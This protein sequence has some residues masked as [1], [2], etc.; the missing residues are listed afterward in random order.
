MVKIVLAEGADDTFLPK[1]HSTE[2][3]GVDLRAFIKEPV[4]LASGE[5]RLIPVG[6]HM[7]LQKG[8]EAQ[9]RPRS[10][11]AVKH[12]VSV[13]NTP[14][15]IDSDYRGQVMVVLINHGKESFTVNPGDRIAQMVIADVRM[16]RFEKVDSLDQLSKTDRGSGG[17]GSTGVQ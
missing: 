6:F 2:A 13:V 1:R 11:L 17:G 10:G 8:T 4:V 7:E 9:I 12:A 5:H 15:T 3:A 14:G 16:D